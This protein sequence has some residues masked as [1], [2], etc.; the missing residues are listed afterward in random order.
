MSW[1]ICIFAHNKA[2]T[3]ARTVSALYDAAAGSAYVVHIM[4]NGSTDD[5]LDMARALAAAIPT[6]TVHASDYA[7]KAS[8]WND[9]VHR[10]APVGA[11]MHIF[12]DGDT[13]PCRA[14]FK[15]LALAL[16]TSSRAWASAGLPASG[17][18][19]MRWTR[20]LYTERWLS[21]NLYALRGATIAMLRTRKIW[22]PAGLLGEDGLISY[23]MHTEMRGGED[24]THRERIAIAAGA[25]FEFDE[26]QPTLHDFA[27]LRDRIWR[28]THRRL[29]NEILYP[30]LKREGVAAMP[31]DIS[32]I[33]TPEAIAA[34]APRRRPLAYWL[35]LAALNQLR[36][37]TR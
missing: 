37:L 23:L 34:L 31:R 20:T 36:T 18:S 32:D 1:S 17:R 30:M 2:D 15:A 9:Y 19:R 29:Q 4:E 26:L 12:L 21:G 25:F 3:L 35:D 10:F 7:D 14:A 5:T 13:R 24:D 6:V 33:Y 11:D 8:A 28:I 22:L 16:E 27:V